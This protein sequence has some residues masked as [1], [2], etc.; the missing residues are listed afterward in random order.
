MSSAWK[1]IVT[2][3]DLPGSMIPVLP[4]ATRFALAFSMPPLV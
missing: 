4:K 3:S 2:F 1:E